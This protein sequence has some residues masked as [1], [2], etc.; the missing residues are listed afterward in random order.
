M[1]FFKV[2]LMLAIFV[3]AALAQAQQYGSQYDEDEY[4]AEYNEPLSK[5]KARQ[6]KKMK[7]KKGDANSSN[8]IVIMNNQQQEFQGY[9]GQVQEQP[10]TFIEAS[11][12]SES[13][14]QRL[15]KA[16]ENLEIKT[17]QKIVEK[18]EESRMEDERARSQRLFGDKLNGSAS[19]YDGDQYSQNQ[20]PVKTTTVYQAPQYQAPQQAPVVEKVD[21]TDIKEEIRSAISDLKDEEEP[22]T[23][24]LYVFANVGLPEYPDVINIRGNLATGFGVGVKLPNRFTF[25]GS[26]KYSNYDI[27]VVDQTGFANPFPSFKEMD[28][29]NFSG[30]A[31]YSVLPTKFTPVVGAALSF[32]RRD[33]TDRQFVI[34]S[35]DTS[36]NA[37]DMG[38]MVGGEMEVTPGFVIGADFTYMTNI[39]FRQDSEV[40]QSF[41]NPTFGNPVEEFDYYFATVSGKFMF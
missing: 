18:L 4:E 35:G 29:Y 15:R 28:Q 41:V 20:Y 32:T 33:Y 30:I 2:L 26:F 38:F 6:L 21:A 16:R 24:Q 31:K 7:K 23:E 19:S 39:T 14:A 34:A 8:K 17:E 12:L 5:I 40:L 37:F 9:Q 36:S 11:P 22:A 25:E 3:P 10:T 13:R 27:E 1:K